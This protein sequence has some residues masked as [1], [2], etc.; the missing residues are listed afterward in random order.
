MSS[1]CPRHL[2]PECSAH[3]VEHSNVEVSSVKTHRCKLT[4]ARM[5]PAV[6]ERAEILLGEPRHLG[7]GER[8][9][10]VG[11]AAQYEWPTVM[12]CEHLDGLFQLGLPGTRVRYANVEVHIN[13]T[14]FS[15]AACVD[16]VARIAAATEFDVDS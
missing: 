5:E 16:G 12:P 4:N 7:F 2:L 6:D 13:D 11:I 3:M 8:R 15:L 9:A 1:L 10:G 14:N